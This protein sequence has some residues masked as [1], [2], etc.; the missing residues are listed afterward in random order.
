MIDGC[1]TTK[2]AAEYLQMREQKVWELQRQGIL[3]TKKGIGPKGRPVLLY[4]PKSVE[5]YLNQITNSTT[6]SAKTLKKKDTTPLNTIQPEQQLTIL[7]TFVVESSPP[8]PVPPHRDERELSLNITNAIWDYIE[9]QGWPDEV[10]VEVTRKVKPESMRLWQVETTYG[11][12][13]VVVQ[14]HDITIIT[15]S[16]QRQLQEEVE[17]L[18][19]KVRYSDVMLGHLRT[20]PREIMMTGYSEEFLVC[21]ET[22]TYGFLVRTD[23]FDF[24]ATGENEDVA[25]MNYRFGLRGHYATLREE[26]RREGIPMRAR[27]KEQ[28]E[29]LKR[30]LIEK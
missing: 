25:L 14:G 11:P 27:R 4:T 30:L 22:H 17:E 12:L 20:K 9:K 19:K 16:L 18:R 23:R 1:Y 29:D 24:A 28:L 5:T 7:P 10:E 3:K 26:E 8:V 2:E 6:P 15:E 21:L 13:Q